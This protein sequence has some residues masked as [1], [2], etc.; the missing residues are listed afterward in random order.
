MGRPRKNPDDPKW[1]DQPPAAQPVMLVAKESFACHRDGADRSFVAGHT[2]IMSNH[3]WLK[4]IE[5]LFEPAQPSRGFEVEA[6][7]AAPGERR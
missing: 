6:A 3:P 2:R 7:T 1:Q 5:H 4:G